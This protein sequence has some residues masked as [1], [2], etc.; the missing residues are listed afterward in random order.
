MHRH[1]GSRS[2]LSTDDNLTNW[3]YVEYRISFEILFNLIKM[4][5]IVG[6]FST[7]SATLFFLA[8]CWPARSRQ[9]IYEARSWIRHVWAGLKA[10]G[11]HGAKG[12]V[13]RPKR[14]LAMR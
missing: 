12:P 9:H 10:V 7:M 6:Y 11:S 14:S 13:L 2:S 5:K 1:I 3:L 4:Q 8:L